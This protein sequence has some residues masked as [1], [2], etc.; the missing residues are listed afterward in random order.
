MVFFTFSRGAFLV[1]HNVGFDIKMLTAHASKVGIKLP[2]FQWS[3][4]LDLANRFIEADSYSLENLASKLCLTHKPN[5]IAINDTR[6]TV[7]LLEILIT[8]IEHCAPYCRDLVNKYG[9]VFEKLSQE[10]ESWRD[11]SQKL[12]P[13]HLLK[14][15]L[16]QSGLYAY[17][18]NDEKRQHNLLKLVR[19][20]H[21][22]D[23]LNLYPDT[24]LRSIIEFTA[25]AKN[26]DQVS[27]QDNQVVMVTV[28]QSKGLE[29][30][31]VFIGGAVQG[32]F[33]NYL[34][35]ADENIEEEKRLFY[36]AM[37]RAKQQ[38][39]ISGF[40]KDSRG[41]SKAISQFI[42]YIPPECILID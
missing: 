12:R 15:L 20:F 6:A 42:K 35:L 9:K 29:F 25:F 27:Q 41:Y 36:V 22:R 37:T 5:H 1:G 33:P 21:E 26:L 2:K 32:E 18:N 31:T 11:D 30:D 14:N 38:L 10:L 3:D 7:E 40:K 16:E 28:H 19:I 17:Y 24:A 13:A 4:T 39:F 34:S 23:N 8:P